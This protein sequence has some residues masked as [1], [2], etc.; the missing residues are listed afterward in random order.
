MLGLAMLV[1][2]LLA[3]D[4]PAGSGDRRPNRLA[5]VAGPPPWCPWT[6]ETVGTCFN[7]ESTATEAS[8]IAR[9]P[10]VAAPRSGIEGPR[11]SSWVDVVPERN[12]H[13]ALFGALP[14]PGFNQGQT[15]QRYRLLFPDARRAAGCGSWLQVDGLV[16]AFYL[17]DQR[18]HWSGQ[19]ATFGAEA[20]LAPL[21]RRQYGAWHTQVGGEFFLNQPFDR[22]ILADTPLRRSYSANFDLDVFEISELFLAIQRGDWTMALGKITTPF[23]RTYF[24]LYTN[25]RADAPFIRTEAILY[26]ETGLLIRYQPGILVVDAAI[27]NGSEDR[28]TNSAKALISRVGLKSA[29]WAVGASIKSQDGIGSEQQKYFNAHVGADAMIRHGPFTLSAEVIYDEYGFR[30]PELDPNDITWGRSIYYRDTHD[31]PFE[32]ITGLGYYIDLSYYGDT[33]LWSLNYGQFH[34]E[35]IGH[36]QHDIVKRRGIVKIAYQMTPSFQWYSVTM[37]ENDGYLAQEGLPRRG[38]FVLA[39]LQGRF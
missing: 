7:N 28:D 6:A 4:A 15:A 16:R 23:G 32:P 38:T 37:I 3:G 2:G 35:Q 11:A 5:A 24:P 29:N 26:R 10:P 36:P 39:G 8:T 18:L 22:N 14:P 12:L 17:N 9:I 34:P 20:I 1:P 13:G 33:W 21:A 27:V 31:R 19:E 25:S 30:R